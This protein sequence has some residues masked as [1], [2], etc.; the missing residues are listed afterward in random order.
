MIL[1]DRMGHMV[2]DQSEEE[3]HAFARK[4]GLKKSWYQVGSPDG[5]QAHYE[6]TTNRR[7]HAALKAGARIVTLREL[8]QRAWWYNNK[9]EKDTCETAKTAI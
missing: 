6:L 1:I 8:L 4:I 3:L 2:S 9:P 5:R 7:Q